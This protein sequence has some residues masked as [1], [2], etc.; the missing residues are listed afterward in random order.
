VKVGIMQP[1]FLPYIGYWQLI[2]AVDIY[3]VYDDVTYIK[4]GWI[5]RNNF[6]INRQKKIFTIILKNS[7]SYR[8]I[9]DIEIIDDFDSF[10]KMLQ[11]NYTKA[12]YFKQ[13]MELILKMINFNKLNLALFIAN[14][15]KVINEYLEINTNIILSSELK[16]DDSLKGKDKV[17][18]ICK[19]LNAT[20]Y[21]N[22][23]GGIE[24]YDKQDFASNGINLHFLKTNITPYKQYDN[25]FIPG[26]S[27]LDIM[28]FNSVEDIQDMLS[29]Y[30]L[31]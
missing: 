16:K 1:Y 4:G 17:I 20:D 8:L 29:E 11:I 27:I 7:S 13:I 25:V 14:T 22:A 21:V 28:M 24:L 18:S 31:V 19:L 26:L 6:L 23:I 15:I 9:K 10:K 12:P 30:T 3:V 5:N 2:K